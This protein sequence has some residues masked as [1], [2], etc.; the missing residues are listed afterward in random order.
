MEDTFEKILIRTAYEKKIPLSGS[1]ELTPLCTMD[2]SM[3][4][5]RLSHEELQKRG[6]VKSAEEWLALA[7]QM[8]NAGTLFILLTGGEPLLHPE[9][10]KIYLGLRKMGMIVTLN[11]NGTLIDEK[12]ANFFFQNPPR[13][14]NISLYGSNELTYEKVCHYKEGYQKT[15]RAIRLLKDRGIQVKINGS[16]VKAN[17]GDLEEIVKTAKE[18]ETAVNVDTYMYPVKK[19]V[20]EDEVRLS[21]EEAAVRRVQFLK[22]YL[23]EEEFRQRSQM[24]IALGDEPEQEEDSLPGMRCQAGRSSF[25]VS[26]DGMMAPCVMLKEVG[27]IPVQ[28]YG[29]Q[30]SWQQIVERTE[31]IRSGRICQDCR[32]RGICQVCAASALHEEGSYW[33]KPE[34]ICRYTKKY[35]E[36]M[37]KERG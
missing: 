8:K 26:W 25:A 12:W 24:E 7:E 19:G 18:L 13:R 37:R 6:T 23:T 9:F 33:K 34:Y 27:R 35:L 4:Y 1:L 22:L 5:V 2:C 15:I 29:F 28:E 10:R 30:R 31:Q 36:E 16:L 20:K 17:A 32:M 21:P 11:T 14:V 3:C